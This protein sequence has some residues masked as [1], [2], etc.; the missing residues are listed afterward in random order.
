MPRHELC[1]ATRGAATSYVDRETRKPVTESSTPEVVRG[2]KSLDDADAGEGGDPMLNRNAML[3]A[4]VAAIFALDAAAVVAQDTTTRRPTS[5]QRITIRK[6]R[7]G[8]VQLRVDTVYSYRTDTLRLPGRTDTVTV[9]RTVTHV[10][11]VQIPMPQIL[12]QIG[13]FYFGLGAGPAM[14]TASF[15]DSD[16]PGWRLEGMVGVDPLGSWF[17]AR[18]SAG[19]NRYTPHTWVESIIGDAQMWNVALDA[20]VRG[21]KLQPLNRRAQIYGVGG[22]TWNRFKNILE[23]DDGQLS[24][25]N[26]LFVPG[27]LGPADTDWHSGWGY[28]LGGGVEFGFSRTNLFIESRVTSFKGQ[29]TMITNVPVIIGLSW[30]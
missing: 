26:N 2:G 22:V 10:D 18:L 3:F 28:N 24:V 19:Y 29:N 6:E 9:T 14:P 30:F 5:S 4:A 13:G 1:L 27:A 21:I 15:N 7:P 12:T 23:N 11:T 20:K 8:E 17:G 25:G 16:H